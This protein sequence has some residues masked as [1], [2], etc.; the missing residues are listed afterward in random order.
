MNAT[1]PQAYTIPR[2]D[3]MQANLATPLHLAAVG[4][5]AVALDFDAVACRPMA[6]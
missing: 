6:V 1:S 2:V 5:Q 3:S 4:D